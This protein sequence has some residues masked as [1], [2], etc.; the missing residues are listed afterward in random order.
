VLH[1]KCSIDSSDPFTVFP[2][3]DAMK[4]A[5]LLTLVLM[6]GATMA[7]AQAAA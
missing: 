6:L 1:D 4:K 7:F 3:G 2:K 5:L